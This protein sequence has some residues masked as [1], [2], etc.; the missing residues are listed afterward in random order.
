MVF[1]NNPHAAQ[2]ILKSRHDRLHK[3]VAT[4]RTRLA[5]RIIRKAIVTPLRHTEPAT[6]AVAA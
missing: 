6:R 1:Y 5:T 2:A 4:E 3:Q